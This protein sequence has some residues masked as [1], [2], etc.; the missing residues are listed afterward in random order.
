MRRYIA[1]GVATLLLVGCG[2]QNNPKKKEDSSL[3]SGNREEIPSAS[4][5]PFASA[6]PSSHPSPTA[7]PCGAREAGILPDYVAMEF[8]SALTKLSKREFQKDIEELNH[9]KALVEFNLEMIKKIF[10]KIKKS[11]EEKNPCLLP[12]GKYTIFQDNKKITLDEIT[13]SKL[14]NETY[15]EKYDFELTLK[16]PILP[17]LKKEKKFVKNKLTWRWED[18]DK[19]L[20]TLYEKNKSR[21]TFHYFTD[22]TYHEQ[23]LIESESED[24]KS[25][26]LIQDYD[27]VNNVSEYRLFMNYFESFKQSFSSNIHLDTYSNVIISENENLFELNIDTKNLQDGDYFLVDTTIYTKGSLEENILKSTEGILTIFNH[28]AQG[29]LFS[30]EFVGQEDKLKLFMVKESRN[31]IEFIE[32]RI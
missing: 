6:T 10:P 8:P 32:T 2:A 28:K 25:N 7:V 18:R 26:Y 11:C 22:Y 23:M 15:N 30:D 31:K 1:F 5:P 3:S 12:N 14:D 16:N 19:N 27:F 20:F 29:F 21:I 9:T 24:K 4:T 13:F 17:S